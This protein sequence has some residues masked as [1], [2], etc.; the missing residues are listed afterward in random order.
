MKIV[1]IF[2]TCINKQFDIF[3]GKSAEENWQLIDESSENDIWFHLS[4][5]PSSHVILKTQNHKLK[6]FNK[7]TFIKCASLCKENSK[8]INQKNIEIIFTQIKNVTKA[9]T[10][11]SVTTVSTK[12]IKI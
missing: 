4:D 7:A 10:V 9:D 2:D 3:I 12:S 1:Q 8:Y 6:E 5:L 11:G